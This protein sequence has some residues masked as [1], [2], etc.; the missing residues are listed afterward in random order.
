MPGH[1]EDCSGVSNLWA[2]GWGQAR[3][4]PRTSER[5]GAGEGRDPLRGLSSSQPILRNTPSNRHDLSHWSHPIIQ[6]Y[7]RWRPPHLWAGASSGHTRPGLSVP[8][9]ELSVSPAASGSDHVPLPWTPTHGLNTQTH[10]IQAHT[11]RSTDGLVGLCKV[12]VLCTAV[13]SFCIIS[14]FNLHYDSSQ[15]VLSTRTHC[16]L[17]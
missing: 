2:G 12:F 1:S 16:R 9:S 7:H 5:C 15:S 6:Q 10:W 3:W 14:S 11:A 8:N 4:S 17:Q 13:G